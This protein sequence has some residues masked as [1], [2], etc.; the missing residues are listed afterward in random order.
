MNIEYFP[1]G[2]SI[3][4]YCAV[5]GLFDVAEMR[6]QVMAPLL[7]AFVGGVS[8]DSVLES[9]L[10]VTSPGAGVDIYMYMYDDRR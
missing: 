8:I 7:M 5:T 3:A 1:L 4:G 6:R 9:D 2:A 10:V